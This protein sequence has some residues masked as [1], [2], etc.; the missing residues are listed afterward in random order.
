[1]YCQLSEINELL[2]VDVPLNK[3]NKLSVSLRLLENYL[4]TF[5][6]KEYLL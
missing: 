4:N 5:A 2:Y 1:M 6:P 3:L